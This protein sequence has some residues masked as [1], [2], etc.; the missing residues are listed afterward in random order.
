VNVQDAGS[1][2]GP[3]NVAADPEKGLGDSAK[4]VRLPPARAWR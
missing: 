4:H 2:V 3:F 1:A